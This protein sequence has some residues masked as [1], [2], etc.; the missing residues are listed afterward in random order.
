MG[1]CTA[2]GPVAG[3]PT[4][5][6]RTSGRLGSSPSEMC[7]LFNLFSRTGLSLRNRTLPFLKNNVAAF[8]EQSVLI[9]EGLEDML[10]T[11]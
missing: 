1:K 4:V 3:E 8:L 6:G 10:S 7:T 9:S 2:Q 11:T 5:R